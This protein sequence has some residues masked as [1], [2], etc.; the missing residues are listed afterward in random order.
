MLVAS[1]VAT[2][3]G[4]GFKPSQVKQIEALGIDWQKILEMIMMFLKLFAKK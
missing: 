2:L 3:K 4:L 1:Q